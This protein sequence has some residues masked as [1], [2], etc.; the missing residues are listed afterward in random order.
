MIVHNKIAKLNNEYELVAV[1]P[2]D[3]IMQPYQDIKWIFIT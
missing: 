1:T 3:E 2:I